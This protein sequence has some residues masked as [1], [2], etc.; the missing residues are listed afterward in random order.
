LPRPRAFIA[1]A[2]VDSGASQSVGDPPEGAALVPEV[3]GL[4]QLLRIERPPLVAANAPSIRQGG[5]TA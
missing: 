3:H 4:L 1:L 5:V 2:T